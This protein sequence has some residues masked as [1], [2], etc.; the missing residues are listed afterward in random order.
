M[1]QVD[2]NDPYACPHCAV[3]D[4]QEGHE[5]DVGAMKAVIEAHRARWDATRLLGF[6]LIGRLDVMLPKVEGV[7]GLQSLRSGTP[8]YDGDGDEMYVR[9]VYGNA[10][11]LTNMIDVAIQ[12]RD[13]LRESV[14]P[15]DD[16]RLAI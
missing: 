7:V 5:C 3:K 1:A 2:L 12:Y 13:A 4:P 14:A 10:A 8:A 16:V 9:G 6:N 15:N 11:V